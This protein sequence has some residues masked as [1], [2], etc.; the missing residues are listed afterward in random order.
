M[1]DMN[2]VGKSGVSPAYT[3]LTTSFDGQMH[4]HKVTS[5]SGVGMELMNFA[6]KVQ[7]QAYKI[8]SSAEVSKQKSDEI[9]LQKIY[10]LEV[11]DFSVRISTS[12]L[13][14]CLNMPENNINEDDVFKRGFIINWTKEKSSFPVGMIN[15]KLGQLEQD[16]Y[17]RVAVRQAVM[18]EIPEESR[19]SVDSIANINLNAIL[20]NIDTAHEAYVD[21][22]ASG[23]GTGV[24]QRK[25]LFE[26]DAKMDDRKV[27]LN[28]ISEADR[29]VRS[30][31][32]SGATLDL[33]RIT[34]LN[35]RLTRG[36]IN[37]GSKPGEYRTA[38]M[39]IM[40]GSKEY[41]AG[42]HVEFEMSE[43]CSWVNEE[44]E[45]AQGDKTK[46]IEIAARAMSWAVSIHPFSDGNGRT[47]RM[48]ANYILM[49]GGLPPAIIDDDHGMVA[50]FGTRVLEM[51]YLNQEN[52]PISD[53]L[54]R[55]SGPKP[56]QVMKYI[57]ESIQVT[58]KQFGNK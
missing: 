21:A 43:L 28:N 16:E 32:S 29:M 8:F 9:A 35:N 47:C 56:E 26:K 24:Q 30:W 33:N 58:I 22:L 44:L 48:L 45:K 34:E 11:G 54:R 39:P 46:V 15:D 4:F 52:E 50:R 55:Q 51:I 57:I 36:T 27:V 1:N 14:K 3:E 17:R 23:S 7:E 53:D 5:W 6:L 19:P 18:E 12:D 42:H 41:L 31:V 20:Q 10:T 25:N 49:K 38:G 2:L 40:A 37:N 13:L